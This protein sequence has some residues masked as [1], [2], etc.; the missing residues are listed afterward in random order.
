MPTAFLDRWAP[1]ALSILRIIAALLMWQ[2]GLQKIFGLL[3]ASPPRPG[4]AMFTLIWF[5]GMI[6]VICSPLLAVGLFTRATAFILS[7]EMAFAYWMS[8]APRNIYPLLNNGELAIMFCF[9]FLYI[10]F[11]GGGVWSVDNILHRKGIK[12]F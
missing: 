10:F 9:V 5:A 7:G 8:H 11:A 1:H 2:H 3:A 4:P 12:T 6:E